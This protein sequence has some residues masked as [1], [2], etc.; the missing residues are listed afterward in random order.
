MERDLTP[1]DRLSAIANC[2]TIQ[3]IESKFPHMV[4]TDWFKRKREKG[5]DELTDLEKFK[6]LLSFLRDYKYIAKDGVAE[7][8][9]A[10]AANVKSYTAIVTGQCMNIASKVTS[11]KKPSKSDNST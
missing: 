4:K 11:N 7:L 1:I 5:L 3:E 2:N 9:R 6:D 8:E 10:K